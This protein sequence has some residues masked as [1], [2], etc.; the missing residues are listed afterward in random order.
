MK[1]RRSRARSGGSRHKRS[2]RL[3]A[4]TIPLAL[5]AT[6]CGGPGDDDA[7]STDEHEGTI[8]VAGPGGAWGEA[9]RAAVDAAAA[10][11]GL[12]VTYHEGSTAPN[13]AQLQAQAQ[14]GRVEFDLIMVND[15]TYTVA[16]A[17][18]LVQAP[19]FSRIPNMSQ[20]DEAWSIP[21][22]VFGSP[23]DALRHVVISEGL[24]YNTEI[25]QE[26]GW[27][28]PT[29]WTD[30][31]D[32]T[33]ADCVILVH[34]SSG[35]SYIPMLNH[36]NTGDFTDYG[37]T[38][39]AIAAVADQIPVFTETSIE[40]LEYIQQGVGCLAPVSQARLLEQREQ[41]APIE[42]V[43]PSEGAGF[44]SAGWVIPNDAPHPNAAHLVLDSLIS[45]EA[46]QRMLE[47]AFLPTTN[48]EVVRPATGVAADLPL[49]AEYAV[50]G[51][52]EIRPDVYERLDALSR[53]WDQL[54]SR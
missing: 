22:E 38:L 15:R 34:P 3:L 17:Q 19:D 21:A 30:L 18:G 52:F 35:L 39:E 51:Y 9:V 42:F 37:P 40:A 28:P 11:H 8:V 5:L 43:A 7:P 4:I 20:L 41:G 12:S 1:Q 10:E 26:R 25:F 44:L 49:V 46:S 36:I 45:A 29:S 14:A 47:E 32:P 23:P 53:E 2:F 33:Y 6:A 13:L 50:L 24:G 16:K 48:T 31:Y 54:L 27:D